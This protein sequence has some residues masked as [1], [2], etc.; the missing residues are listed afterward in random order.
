[1]KRGYYC[2]KKRCQK[3]I[4]YLTNVFQSSE[5]LILAIKG[6]IFDLSE[7]IMF[8]KS[9]PNQLRFWRKVLL[10]VEPKTN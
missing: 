5:R 4:D 9:N 10:M 6:I 1:M 2:T 3:E 8:E 7:N